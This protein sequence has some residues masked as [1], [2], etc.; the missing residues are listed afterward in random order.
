VRIGIGWIL[1]HFKEDWINNH[2]NVLGIM[3]YLN[4]IWLQLQVK[5]I[6]FWMIC[7][8]LALCILVRIGFAWILCH[9]KIRLDK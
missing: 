5:D 9:F 1:C 2:F 6:N 4:E 7:H 3:Y 8:L